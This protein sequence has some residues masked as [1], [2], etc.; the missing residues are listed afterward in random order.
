MKSIR[1]HS[2]TLISVLA[3]SLTVA[4]TSEKVVYKSGTDFAAPPAA[5]ANFVGYYDETN[6]Q[7][8]CGS[9]HIEKQVAWK[10]TKHAS[11]WADLQ[12]NTSKAGYCEA[13]HSTNNLGNA[14]TD[15]AS[16]YRST[17]DARFHDVQCESCHGPGL[18][19]ASAPNA[20]NRPLASIKADTNA[21]NGCGECHTGTHE[22][23]AEEWK[24]SG[25]SQTWDTSHNS[26]DPYCQGC[27]T[28]QGALLSWGKGGNYVEK[29]STAMLPATC[30][31]C[32]DP[33]GSP[34]TAQLR[35]SLGAA[36]LE[37]NLCI[38]CHQRRGTVQ[39]AVAQGRNSVH[40]PEGPTLLG[41]A[42]W[43]PPGMSVSDSIIGTHGS[44]AKNPKL[45][46]T[47]HVQKFQGTDPTTK[48]A[49][50]ST[51]HR[52]LA[53][54]CVGANGLPLKDQTNCQVSAMTFRSC[55][56][57]GCHGTETAARSAFTTATA[58]ITNL[59]TQA[60]NL[61]A[62]A[63][64]GPKK[65]ECTFSATA[66]YSTCMGMQFNISVA[67]K[68][69]GVVHNPFLTEKLMLAS[70]AQMQKDYNLTVASSLDMTPQFK[71]GHPSGEGGR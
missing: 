57:S 37:D 13:C 63:K 27:H 7:T 58:R 24:L 52:F 5:A 9:C 44:S 49:V 4:C 68:V 40:S 46:A 69:G 67:T 18:A 10:A 21:T 66:P 25:H 53:T 55:I 22:P 12:S 56:A 17:K 47:C 14:V 42:G 34:N 8:V 30:A 28:G 54:P 64:L 60:N 33:H 62:Q 15:T 11:A 29:G 20:S 51:G 31:T 39:D 6:K 3:A 65:A 59:V 45:C 1:L 43:F 2:M 50:F 16:G 38:K 32:H 71:K 41:Q 61:I 23:F 70:I 19:H 48:A 35:F 26:T 36:N